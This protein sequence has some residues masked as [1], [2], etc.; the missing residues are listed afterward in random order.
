MVH[1]ERGISEDINNLC[2][3]VEKIDLFHDIWLKD[4]ERINWRFVTTE[5][6]YIFKV[7][8]SIFDL[9]Q[10]VVYRIWER[11]QYADQTLQKKKNSEKFCQDAL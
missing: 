1:F 2:V 5:I 3:S 8:R 10:E 7:C 9:L 11:F 4:A 6:E